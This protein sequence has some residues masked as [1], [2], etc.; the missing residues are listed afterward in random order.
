MRIPPSWLSV[1]FLP[2][3]L[4]AQ[5]PTVKPVDLP[6]IPATPPDK[7]VATF[8]M[9]PGFH[10]ELMAAEPTIVSPVAMS[11]DENG[12]LYVVEMI[13]YSERRDEKLSRIKLLESTK[14]DGHYDK[15]TIFADHLPCAT[16]VMCWDGGVFVLASPDLFYF[17]D[18]KGDGH[19]DVHALVATGFGV[20]A[21]RLNVQA[22]P[23]YLQW[24]PDQRIQGALG[25]NPSRMSS[26][27]HRE[28]PPLELR[29][30]DF[31]FDPRDLHLRAEMGG[32]QW[33]FS[34][35]NAGRK[36]T[37]SNS[38]YI[39]QLLYGIS[40]L[41]P[42]VT[43]PPGTVD[44]GVDGPQAEIY[45][46]SPDEAWRVIRTAWRASSGIGLIEGGGRPSGYFSGA[47][48]ITIYR[49]DAYPNE[50]R[51]DA[52]MADC[53][54]NL[55]HRTK[56]SGEVLLKA[57]RA[58]DEQKSEFAASRDNWSRPVFLTDGP[59]GCL[60]FCDMYREVIE[61]PWSLPEALK[62]QL[63][64]NSGNDRGRLYRLVPDGV[65]TR[66]LP[67]LGG[68]SSAE[69]VALLAHP[70]GWH[71]DTAARLLHQRQD[72][73]AAPAL[74]ELA[75]NPASPL[76][77][78]TALRVL[79]GDGDLDDVLL[80]TALADADADV[81]VQAIHTTAARYADAPVPAAVDA[82]LHTLGKDESGFVRY[83]LAWALG[84]LRVQDKPGLILQ[85]AQ[86]DASDA[87]PRT[88]LLAAA[89][90]QAG[91]LFQACVRPDGSK[92]APAFARELASAIG[93]RKQPAEVEAVITYAVAS[94]TPTDWLA[95]LADGLARSGS[96]LAKADTGRKLQPL[97]T[98]AE[99]RIRHNV[100]TQPLDFTILGVTGAPGSVEVVAA[101]LSENLSAPLTSAALEALNRLNPAT[102]GQILTTAWPKIPAVAHGAALRLWRTRPQQ[103]PTLLDAITAKV[104][105]KSDLT[106]E[107]LAALRESK[108]P[109]IHDRAVALFGA[110]ISRERVIAAFGPSL[111]MKGDPAKG[112]VTFT[113]RCTV[114]HRFHGEGNSVGP[115]LDASAAAGREKL[116]GNILDPSRE[117]T[118][119]FSM[120]IVE[121]K[122]GERVA[123]IVASETDAAVALRTPGGFLRTIPRSDVAQVEHSN[124]SLMP[125]GIEAGLTPQDL[126][127]LLE[128]LSTK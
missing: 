97:I 126:A 49:G 62:S 83:E 107:D 50:Y 55:I 70:D 23:N 125:E 93:T 19:A 84:G 122:S 7:A 103:V 34:Y 61:H 17:K 42:G 67:K 59:D 87:W 127:D 40:A 108:T 72:H 75:I 5:D 92:I 82:A 90:D 123:G 106:A 65:Q 1:V 71:R 44:I 52:F 33:G 12:K 105:A 94:A 113:T 64:L 116:M 120:V 63:D 21:D 15:A 2:C 3:A 22:L 60:W 68:L 38:R 88:A 37:C 73:T 10:L 6:R 98:A 74:R 119:G 86:R 51:G 39:N 115:E 78:L 111:T 29:G 31:S 96:T 85:L 9:R 56:L 28:D 18:T 27:A 16:S 77:R 54:S 95:P 104:V 79:A 11:W 69:L 36:F 41:R 91:D 58:A 45:R 101:A 118:Q 14:G 8:T 48:G 99:D 30:R 109:E 26:F 114:C 24:G 32:G 110:S 25:G 46:T 128:F 112:H 102:L 13:D 81:R 20:L 47:E 89:G 35:D 66:P 43:L 124:R 100:G 4:L 121:T 53:G 117:I 57:E 76:G 80:A